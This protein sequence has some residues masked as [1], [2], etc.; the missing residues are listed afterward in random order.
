MKRLIYLFVIF[1]KLLTAPWY[2]YGLISSSDCCVSFVC[3]FVEGMEGWW[4]VLLIA[5]LYF[6]FI[7]IFLSLETGCQEL[8]S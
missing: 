3:L 5:G 2:I 8:G 6:L 7:S 1:L 4:L